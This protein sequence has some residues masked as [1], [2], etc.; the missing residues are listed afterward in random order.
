MSRRNKPRKWSNLQGQLAADP[1]ETTLSPWMEEV[2][3]LKDERKDKTMDEL[4]LEFADLEEEEAFADLATSERNK[5]FKAIELRVLDELKRVEAVAG[6][7]MWRGQGQTFSP[8]YTPRPVVT[9]P[10]ALMQWIRETGQEDQL[11]LSA[12]RLKSIVNEVLDTELAALMSPAARAALKPGDAGSGLLP[13]GVAAFL[14]TSVH[15]TSAKKPTSG[16]SDP[17][18]VPF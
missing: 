7:D 2:L 3:V 13:P 4:A 5:K 12:P 10:A 15:H 8:K 17:D 11:T 18:D 1:E 6:T 14:Q 9:D 16:P